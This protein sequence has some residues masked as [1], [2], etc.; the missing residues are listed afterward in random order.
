MRLFALEAGEGTPA[1]K[2]KISKAQRAIDGDR[3]VSMPAAAQQQ[4]MQEPIINDD[5]RAAVI[6]RKTSAPAPY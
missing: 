1:D 6:D 5:D 4:Q 3:K 2:A